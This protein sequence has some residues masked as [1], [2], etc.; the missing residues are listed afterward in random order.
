MFDASGTEAQSFKL[1]LTTVDVWQ[2]ISDT[3]SDYSHHVKTRDQVLD[4]EIDIPENANREAIGDPARIA[5]VLTNLL[6]NAS[7]YSWP[8]S[9][10]TVFCGLEKNNFIVK[11]LDRGDGINRNDLAKVFTP[12]FR[13]DNAEVRAVPDAGLGLTIVKSIVELHDGQVYIESEKG[14]GTTVSFTI[15]TLAST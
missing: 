6:S 15:P 3:A 5:Q 12:F 7:K 11:V 14:R 1:N 13:V 8:G 2:V 10:I 4:V 9:K